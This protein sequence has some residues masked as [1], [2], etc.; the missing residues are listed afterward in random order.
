M[1]VVS[2]RG[3][4]ILYPGFDERWRAKAIN[5]RSEAGTHTGVDGDE[6]LD[7]PH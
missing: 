6:A 2:R 1:L 5:R 7:A 4:G 3:W